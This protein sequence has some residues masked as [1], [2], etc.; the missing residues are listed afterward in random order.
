MK[1][2]YLI[3]KTIPPE[4]DTHTYSK[5]FG[6]DSL[7]SNMDCRVPTD[8]VTDLLICYLPERVSLHGN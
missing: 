1:V 4:A 5:S 8:E 7:V 3:L 2:R 6:V